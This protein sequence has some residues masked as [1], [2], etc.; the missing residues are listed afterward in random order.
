MSPCASATDRGLAARL[1]YPYGMTKQHARQAN[2]DHPIEDA[3]AKRWSPY[4]YDPRPVERD[5]LL[6]CLEAARWAASSFNEQPWSLIV[7]ERADE[8]A[9]DAALQC[10][11]EANQGW[12]KD[13]GVLILTVVRT[14]FTR[15][16]N[17]NRVAEHDLGLA[18]GNLCI[19][20][21]A[22]GLDVHQMGGVNLAKVRQ[23]YDIPS[24][25]EP[26]TA[27]TVGYAGDPSQ[28]DPELAKRDQGPRARKPLGE[29][30]FAGRWGEAASQVSG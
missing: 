27:M 21:A 13:A 19:Q 2:P 15:N 4:V 25:Y 22:L 5:K 3:I 9:F 20:A 1:G 23:T 26:V 28:A 30:V 17:P 8:Q 14:T 7:A 12:A 11:V 18:V 6:S 10:L 16:G 29:W 24:G